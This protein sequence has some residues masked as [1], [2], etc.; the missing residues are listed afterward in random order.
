M[1]RNGQWIASIVLLGLFVLAALVFAYRLVQADTTIPRNDVPVVTAAT[2]GATIDLQ[3]LDAETIIA[4]NQRLLEMAKWTIGLVVTVGG[5]LIGYSWF[6]YAGNV[7]RDQQILDD[8]RSRIDREVDNTLAVVR[9]NIDQLEEQRSQLDTL[10][11]K[12]DVM[13]RSGIR[14]TGTAAAGE[15]NEWMMQRWSDEAYYSLIMVLSGTSGLEAILDAL[16]RYLDMERQRPVG[17]PYPDLKIRQSLDAIKKSI[18]RVIQE[19]NSMVMVTAVTDE[20]QTSSTL[21]NFKSERWFELT[22]FDTYIAY[23]VGL[24]D[25]DRAEFE[26]ILDRIRAIYEPSEDGSMMVP[27]LEQFPLSTDSSGAK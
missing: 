19:H 16:R 9:S 5:L 23:L 22:S 26:Q 3:R 7:R 4:T 25:D 20:M 12:V 13:E 14:T 27:K 10:R 8:H 15:V 21:P 24:K 1:Q 2:P 18:D 6:Q 17:L 11:R